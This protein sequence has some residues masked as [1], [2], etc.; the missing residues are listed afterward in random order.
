MISTQIW[1]K[2][3]TLLRGGVLVDTVSVYRQGDT[4]TTGTTA[5]RP[6]SPIALNVPG[7][8]QSDDAGVYTIKTAEA[9]DTDMV[10]E[11]VACH[12]QP[13]LVGTYLAVDTVS[14]NGLICRATALVTV[15]QDRQVQP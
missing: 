5:S 4:V 7:L 2:A 10:V 1:D 15:T 12:G 13:S 9:L 3:T 11:V 14:R 6:L 8:V